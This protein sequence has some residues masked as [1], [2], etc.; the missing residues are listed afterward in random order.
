MSEDKSIKL[1]KAVKE[2]NIGMGTIVDFLATK[3]YK[4]EKQPMAKLDNDMYTTLLK[5]FAV[6]K[7]IKEEAKQIK[8]GNIRK[9]E[10]VQTPEK[11][12]EQPRR[13]RDF[14]NEEILIKNTGHFTSPPAEKP[15]PAEPVQE[16]PE[17]RSSEGLPGVKVI[18]KID[19]NNLHAKPQVEQKAAPVAE[20]PKTPEPVAEKPA[21]VVEAPK[22][23]EPVAEKPAPVVE[24][25]KAPEPVAEKPAP[26]VEA[27]KAPVP[28]AEQP[29]PVV[30]EAPVAAVAPEAAAPA[31]AEG[32]DVIRASAERLSGPKIIGKI[33]LPVNQPKRGGPVASSSSAA[34]NAAD[35]KRKRKRKD[36]QGGGNG[37]GQQAP[38]SGTINPNRPDFRNRPPGAPGGGGGNRPDFR[39]GRP[40]PGGG[41]KEE[42][43]EKDIQ[44]QIKATLARLSGAGKSGKFAQRAKF[45]RQKRD[46]VAATA[47]E[48][49]MEQDAMSKV[50]K[51]TE[52]VTANE[53]ALMMDVSVTQIISTCMS[54][55]MFVSINQRLD[56]ETLSI[57]AEE[58]GYQV[59]FVK[60]QD[61]EANLDQPD[62]PADLIPRAPIVTIMGHVD[63]GKTS[64]LD[65]I[66]K[67]NV[68]GGEAGGITQHIG[69]YEVTL[70]D[71]KGKITFLDTPGH[72][73]FTA[74]RARGAQVTDIVIIVIA[75]DD[76]VMPQT[77]EAINH[78]QAAGAP[79][80]FAFNKI[81]RPGANADKVREQLSAMNI[82][83]EEW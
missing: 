17:E 56:A 30:A 64:L 65:F 74:M 41:P 70:P 81:D 31:E 6:D 52:F 61:E 46:D 26:V 4:V 28:V 7:I 13:S 12:A 60:P 79:I 73:A 45:R 25:P 23:A 82:L 69:A 59:E 58:F 48:L 8:I 49:A 55:G 38:P 40:A 2:L 71:N 44:D 18:G 66:R 29:A 75:A 5:E 51:V 32:D 35:Q 36:Q 67:T 27:P 72:E 22:A 78:A 37:T 68:I 83:V 50:I 53:L 11:P 24:A 47:E 34:G 54:L 16:K 33:Q 39:G 63:H 57:V 19:L 43:T 20:A 1:I 10:G 77:R 76:S 42:P 21:P 15:K 9:E 62:D 14:E 3:G 80:I